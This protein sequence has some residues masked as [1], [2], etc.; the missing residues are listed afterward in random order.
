MIV[1]PSEGDVIAGPL[2]GEEG[3]VI[4]DCD[5]R[6]GLHAKRLFDAA[7]HYGREDTLLP[8]LAVGGPEAGGR[9]E[10][11]ALETVALPKAKPPPRAGVSEWAILDSNQGPPPYQSG[12]LTN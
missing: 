2:Y 7:G 11:A 6:I 12:A 1:E 9:L 10:G 3:I 8:L 4:A 5:L